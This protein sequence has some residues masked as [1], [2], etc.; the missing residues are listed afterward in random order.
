MKPQLLLI[1]ACS[2]ATIT[3]LRAHP[4]DLRTWTDLQQRQVQASLHAVEGDSVVL[5][6]A[7]GKKV[8]YPIA[9]LSAEDVAY[10]TANRAKLEAGPGEANKPTSNEATQ[11]RVANFTAAWPT[12]IK[13]S[14]DPEIAVIEENPD[15][16]R[17][18]YE[19]ASY[20]YTSDVRLAKSVIK[21]FAL[22][23]ESTSLFCR[24]LPLSVDGGASEG[25]KLPIILFEQESSYHAA[26]GP[27]G[28]CLTVAR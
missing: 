9:K 3:P 20:R 22:M 7:N 17:F 11:P 4:A 10:I 12:V 26:G 14:D 21:G 18:V 1:L 25:G 19:S 6:L 2:A 24:S 27:Q 8:P 23:F 13:F 16:K 5:E 15:A 28:R